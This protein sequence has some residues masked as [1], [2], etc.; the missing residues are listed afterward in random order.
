MRGPKL[1]SVRRPCVWLCSFSCP[2]VQ[3]SVIF[4][5]A[6][7]GVAVDGWRG[8]DGVRSS[9]SVVELVAFFVVGAISWP[10]SEI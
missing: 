4:R 9:V 3:L 7:D 8:G 5:Y 10:F 6:G 1:A 2:P